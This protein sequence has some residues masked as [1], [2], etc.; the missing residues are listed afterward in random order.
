MIATRA[1]GRTGLEVSIVGLGAGRIGDPSQDERELERLLHGA[2]DRGVTLVDTARSYGLSEERIGRLLASR[3]DAYALSTKVGYGVDGVPDWTGECVRRGVDGALERMR[4]DRIELVFLHSC[5]RDVLERGEVVDALRAAKQAGK[6]RAIGYSGENDALAWALAS[7]AFDVVQCSINVADQRSID[8]ALPAAI[9]RGVAVLAK[10][11]LA[12]AAFALRERP[13]APDTATYFD[14]LAALAL[15]PRGVEWPE[16]ALRFTAFTPGVT[17]AI[18]GTSRL[19][20]LEAAIAWAERGPLD[21]D[22]RGAIRGAFR[23]QGAGWP[24]VV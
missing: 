13:G 24:G 15:D 9:E 23:A 5:P 17:S 10:R 19:A 7:G 20:H 1:L 4:T 14:R 6:V 21:E 18:V 2:L 3:R 22:H 12:N 16:L 11:P 8:D